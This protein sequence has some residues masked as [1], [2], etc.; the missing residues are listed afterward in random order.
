MVVFKWL[1]SVYPMKYSFLILIY[2]VTTFS[3]A[4]FLYNYFEK[5][6]TALRDKLK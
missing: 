6:F 4:Y 1:A 3:F 2:I 5:P